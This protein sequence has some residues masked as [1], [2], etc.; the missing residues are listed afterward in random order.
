[1]F[2]YRGLT[3]LVWDGILPLVVATVPSLLLRRR[4]ALEAL[5]ALAVLFVPMIAALI[6]CCVGSRQLRATIGAV[7]LRRQF[8][9]AVAIILLLFFEIAA[10]LIRCVP[11][12]PREAW[13]IAASLYAAYL[14]VIWATFRPPASVAEN[15]FMAY[16]D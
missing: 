13:S 10:N 15:P 2:R 8:G 4:G 7:S 5:G 16:S 1:M 14:V 3:F 6:R 11:D 9:L 12:I